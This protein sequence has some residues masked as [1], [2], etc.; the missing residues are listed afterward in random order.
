MSQ[1]LL[2]C[3]LL[4]KLYE[5]NAGHWQVGTVKVPTN[6][7]LSYAE[8][9]YRAV[10]QSK[11]SVVVEIGMCFGFSSLAILSALR[12]A[13]GNGRLI[14]IDPIQSTYWASGGIRNIQEAELRDRHELIEDYSY[15]ALPRLLA[16]GLRID[17]GY[18]DGSHAFDDAI[19]DGLYIDK[20]LNVGG[21]IGFNDAGWPSVS[22]VVRFLLAYRKYVELDVGLRWTEV[23][24]DLPLKPI[25]TRVW[26][27]VRM[28]RRL[29]EKNPYSNHKLAP[30]R[31]L[32]KVEEWQP[33]DDYFV[34]F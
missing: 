31:Y 9:L 28:W 27:I 1:L 33:R 19:I 14:S 18:V 10:L 8:A 12:A 7:P 29:A 3:P 32:K 4:R 13:G 6:I 16:S 11:P 23:D 26:W 2:S 20:M 21:V 5:S 22:K 30:D 15:N 34:Q 17:F 25:L 24:L